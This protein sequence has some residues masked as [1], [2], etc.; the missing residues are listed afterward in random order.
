LNFFAVILL[1]NGA[2]L[3]HEGLAL[4]TSLVAIF[5]A[6]AL[7]VLMRNRVGGIYGRKL[8]QTFIRVSAASGVMGAAVWICSRC[9]ATVAGT[10]KIGR[11]TDLAI[12]IPV[13]LMVL[14]G[15]CR[16]L[17]IKELDIAMNSVLG[18][19]QRRLQFS[20]ARISKQ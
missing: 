13:G 11:L 1:L 15:M 10:S 14:Y 18:T 20:R 5:S 7:L 6:I 16:M 17:E 2:H 9:V 4:S 3:G 8:W 19:L 12:S